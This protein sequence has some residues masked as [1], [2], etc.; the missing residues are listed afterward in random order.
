M[1][2]HMTDTDILPCPFCGGAELEVEYYDGDVNL[3][4]FLTAKNL[5]P[6]IGNDL[7][8]TSSQ[9]EFKRLNGGRAVRGDLIAGQSSWKSSRRS[10]P[11]RSVDQRHQGGR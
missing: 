4:V 6:F 9:I 11:R 3:P 7:Y 1:E 2:H 8:V 5:K 10:W